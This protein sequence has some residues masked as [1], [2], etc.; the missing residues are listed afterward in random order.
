[1]RIYWM[2]RDLRLNDNKCFEYLSRESSTPLVV[3]HQV[4]PFLESMGKFRKQFYLGTLES[5]KNDLNE[6]GL[7]L[8]LGTISIECLIGRLQ[9]DGFSIKELIYTSGNNAR[10]FDQERKLYETSVQEDFEIRSFDQNTLIPKLDLPF[11]IEKL[12]KSFTGFRKKVETSV[13][14]KWSNN[15]KLEPFKSP[16]IN[17]GIEEFDHFPNEDLELIFKPGETSALNRLNHYLWETKSVSTYKETRNGMINFDDSTKFSPWLSLGSISPKTIMR[18]LQKYEHENGAN[19]ST[20]WVFF[21]LL[22]RDYFKFLSEKYKSKFFEFDGVKKISYEV[23]DREEAK[24]ELDRWKNGDT[25]SEFVN[26]NMIELKKTGWMSNRGR[27]NVASYLAKHLFIDWTLGAC[28]FEKNLIDY[29]VE[30][31]WGN[32]AYLAGAGVDPRD[33]KFDVDR[34]QRIYDPNREYIKK[35]LGA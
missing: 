31:N 2:R 22:W 15:S 26:A 4:D 9:N 14:F 30:S 7:H 24:S 12:P 19:E 18:E 32:W 23:L 21:E 13:E 35:F 27:Q 3:Y 17:V 11:P 16:Q 5:L 29:D 6:K 34:Q 10:D 1:M 33:R 28:W 8:H 20:Y 25:A